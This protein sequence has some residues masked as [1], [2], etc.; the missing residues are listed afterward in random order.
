ML[1]STLVAG[2]LTLTL[3]GP[4]HADGAAPHPNPTGLRSA[5]DGHRD[6]TLPYA[7]RSTPPASSSTLPTPL[8]RS[9]VPDSLGA[10]TSST[11]VHQLDVV[12]V[13]PSSTKKSSATTADVTSL[14]HEVSSYWAGQSAGRVTFRVKTVQRITSGATC[15]TSAGITSMWKAASL[16]V[17]KKD[18]WAG[19]APDTG[20]PAREHLVVLYPFASG[21]HYGATTCDQTLGL[22]TVPAKAGIGN[23]GLTFALFGSTDAT[24]NHTTGPEFYT[25][26]QSLAHELGHNFGLQH[27]SAWWC[28]SGRNDGA[29]RSAPCSMLNYQ[30]P[31]DVMGAGFGDKGVPALSGPQKLRLGLLS[32]SQHRSVADTST[33]TLRPVP[34]SETGAP[35]GLQA[36]Q[37]KDP[38]TGEVYT[39]EYRPS[40][41]GVSFPGVPSPFGTYAWDDFPTW[42]YTIGYG[43]RVLRLAPADVDYTD[44]TQA[45]T[46]YE[47]SLVPFGPV[48][49]RTSYVPAGQTFTTR[50]GKVSIRVASQ[51]STATVAFVVHRKARLSLSRSATSQRYRQTAVRL[52]AR[53]ATTNGAVPTGT[54]TFKDGSKVLRTVT[55]SSTGVASYLLPKT[56]SIKTH[57]ITATF[58]PGAA[59]K[60][61][62]VEAASAS[63]RVAVTKAYSSIGVRLAHTTVHK[64]AKPRLAVRL[65]VRGYSGPT[66]VVRIYENGHKVKTVTMYASRKGAFTVTLPRTTRK[67]TIKIVAKYSG[68]STILPRNSATLRLRVI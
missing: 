50:S 7:P 62:N 64:G 67:G 37:V 1:T 38:S 49:N 15:R 10:A 2:A 40:L 3:A 22:G 14:V 26:R 59:T 19:G 16:K 17:A 54:V 63:A 39:V 5:T 42:R 29:Y 47:Q 61:R 20:I 36:A 18:W 24:V 41:P 25:S 60:A 46:K 6:D 34:Q 48:T 8:L 56:L 65:T 53:T 55:T 43:V 33:V 27:A 9:A 28:S 58:T 30:D 35:S 4:A 44:G 68:T 23:N 31:F 32:T 21:D 51:G 45:W 52:T 11:A 66:G 12:I 13:D 57:T